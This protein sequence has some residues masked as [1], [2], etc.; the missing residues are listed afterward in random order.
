MASSDPSPP[1]PNEPEGYPAVPNPSTHWSYVNKPT[2]G[3]GNPKSSSAHA[4]TPPSI[5]NEDT[6]SRSRNR[7][8]TPTSRD[9]SSSSSRSRS[10]SRSRRQHR[11]RISSPDYDRGEGKPWYQKKSMWTGLATLATVAALLPSGISAKASRDAASASTRAARASE[12]SA[13]E[14]KKSARA[15]ELSA[16][17]SLTSARAVVSSS[18][19]QGHMDTNGY[20]VCKDDRGRVQRVHPN[21]AL[22]NPYGHGPHRVR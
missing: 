17:G 19:A 6:R 14:V 21:A 20:A 8:H 13:R 3:R 10:R 15:S 18:M 22:V 5:R 11:R 16:I 7:N 1:F 4:R 2:Q 12:K 9:S